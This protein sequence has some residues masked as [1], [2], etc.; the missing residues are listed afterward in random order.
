MTYMG[1]QRYH[2]MHYVCGTSYDIYL[3]FTRISWKKIS[4]LP[5]IKSDFWTM[6]LIFFPSVIPASSVRPRPIE[7]HFNNQAFTQAD[8][9]QPLAT[10]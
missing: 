1:V 3:Y 10:T 2:S 8:G 5:L 9:P 4:V 7:W 6:I